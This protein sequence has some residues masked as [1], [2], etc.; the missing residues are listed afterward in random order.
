MG[1]PI[2]TLVLD[3]VH[4][5]SEQGGRHL[6]VTW[7][8]VVAIGAGVGFFSGLFGRGGSAIATPLLYAAG[9]P[10]IVSL[11]APLPA[12]LPSTL[13]ASWAYW[14]TGLVDW[15]AVGWCLG[16]GLPA[17]A[18]GALATRWIDG[19]ALVLVTDLVAIALGVRFVLRPGS[20]Q[21]IVKP[22]AA[23]RARLA[24]VAAGV[25]I[26]SGLL[27]NSGGF[28]L[29]PLFLTALRMPIKTALAT[30]LAV[31]AALAVPGTIVHWALGHIDWTLVAVYAVSSV[32]LSYLGAR[33]AIRTQG[34]RLERWF[35]VFIAVLGAALLIVS[36]R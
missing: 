36:F 28:L 6:A 9:F 25:G 35:G 19:A 30:S 20:P 27:A 29:V 8:E 10:A 16:V 15:E 32:P 34:R 13:V 2:W 26:A 1:N 14:N 18:L 31:S 4:W 5:R 22:V 17:T 21:E 3:L 33:I 23:Y 11:A 7:L 12:A 24:C